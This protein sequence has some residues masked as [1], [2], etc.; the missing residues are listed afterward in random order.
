MLALI[1]RF[2]NPEPQSACLPAKA[3][4]NLEYLVRRGGAPHEM[5]GWDNIISTVFSTLN[6]LNLKTKKKVS[7][8]IRT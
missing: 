1:I 3:G 8:K 7:S 2:T 6:G 4:F 5:R